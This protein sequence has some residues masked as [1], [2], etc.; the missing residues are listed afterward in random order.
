M[1]KIIAQNFP[2]EAL[3]HQSFNRSI[4]NDQDMYPGERAVAALKIVEQEFM[5][6]RT[7]ARDNGDLVHERRAQ[8]KLIEI[9][10]A[11]A[12]IE[13]GLDEGDYTVDKS[14]PTKIIVR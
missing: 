3:A 2:K 7:F 1:N 6:R 9:R 4:M 11:L 10:A 8:K 12:L 5:M 14:T 13:H